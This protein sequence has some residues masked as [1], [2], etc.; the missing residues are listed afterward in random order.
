MDNIDIN[1]LLKDNFL[2]LS[3]KLEAKPRSGDEVRRVCKA[4]FIVWRIVV[5]WAVIVVYA[6]DHKDSYLI[7]QQNSHTPPL[8]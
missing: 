3:T 7:N 1:M 5:T 8:S 4:F 2:D 6:A